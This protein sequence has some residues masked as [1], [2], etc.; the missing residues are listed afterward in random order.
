[1][2]E[3]Y[4]LPDLPYD[5]AALEPHISARIMELH[6]DKHHATYVAGA[7]TAIEKMEE[8]REK[9]DFANIGKLSKD[10]AFNLGGHTNHSVFWTNLS[11]EGGDKPTGELAAAIDEF[12]G[13]FDGFREHFTNVATTIQGS[14]WAILAWDTV[15]KR[16]V[17]EQLYDQQGNI[18]VGLIPVLQ[19]DMW[20]HAFY[21]DYQNVKGDYVK[22]FWN[23]VNWADVQER[24]ARATSQTKGLIISEA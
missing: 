6:H 9:G 7:N 21:L 20:E 10:L 4:V 11:P 1:M 5:Y 8:A 13:S 3:K 24:F 19:L 17:I 15:G 18:S 16:L 2:A 22:A 14:G 12:F 23:I